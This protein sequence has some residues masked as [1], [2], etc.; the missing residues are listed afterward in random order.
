M[1]CKIDVFYLMNECFDKINEFELLFQQESVKV[2]KSNCLLKWIL[3]HL[4]QLFMQFKKR[5]TSEEVFLLC[6]FQ[7]QPNEPF[8]PFYMLYDLISES[9]FFRL[10][11]DPISGLA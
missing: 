3:S 10:Y 9:S 6:L 5:K 7:I 1:Y 11:A 2:V 8:D 4:S